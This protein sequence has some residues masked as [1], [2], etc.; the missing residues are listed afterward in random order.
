MQ[1]VA[2]RF[3]LDDTGAAI[4]LA[5]GAR[6][7]LVVEPAGDVP[8]QLRWNERCE[9]LHSLRHHALAPLTDYGLTG[10]SSR[11]EAWACAPGWRGS[12][13]QARSV[14]ARAVRFLRAIHVSVGMREDRVGT[15]ANGTGL[16]VPDAGTGY[17]IDSGSPPH[18]GLSLVDHGVRMIDRPAVAA[19]AEIFGAQFGSRSHVASLWGPRESGKRSA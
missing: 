18:E 8:Q 10:A 14:S 15:A 6:V 3:A 13:D 17:P 4:D 16:L 1:L 9:T 19:L 5:T 7:T 11:F 12:P 2:D